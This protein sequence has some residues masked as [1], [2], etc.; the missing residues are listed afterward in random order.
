LTTQRPHPLSDAFN[1]CIVGG[2]GH[3]GLPLALSFTGADQR[4]VVYDLNE[5]IFDVIRSGTMPFVEQGADALLRRALDG[6][7]IEFTAD[8]AMISNCETV[9]ITI[10]T[11][12]DEFLNP[13]HKAVK[14]CIDALLPH[15]RDGQLIVLRSTV[16]PGTTDWLHRYLI[17]AGKSVHL[18]FCPERV[19]QG[20]AIKELAETPQI[21]SATTPEALAAAR[22]LFEKV[23]PEII[24]I[25]P[26]EAEFAKLF[27]NT[28]RYIQ[29]AI[30]NQFYMI[31]NSAGVDYYRIRHA[32]MHNYPRAKDIPAA[33]F[34]AGPC[35]F[36]DT[37]QLTAFARNSFSLGNAAM[38]VNEG[39]V[40]YIIDRLRQTYRLEDMT[41][42]LLGMA[43]KPDSDDTRASLS[44]KIRK[45]LT[46]L[47]K[48]ILITDPL[49]T[50]IDGLMPVDEVVEKS[51]LLILCVPHSAYRGL[52]TRGKPTIDIWNYLDGGT[53]RI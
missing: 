42:G 43:F 49:V 6:A 24:E 37:M 22:S 12:V 31:A 3:V 20:L 14:D 53:F 13:V 18:A 39:L 52:D 21:I 38:L 1:I 47:A 7:L 16:Y 27:N 44:F 11:P 25:D 2:A 5:P 48:S 23:S 15:L 29:F 17:D 26:M 45:D 41:V 4:V 8:P 30:T 32:M 34:T 28:Y 51:D 10:G 33:G 9:I 36:K 50:G 35:L 46:I 19:V 40:L